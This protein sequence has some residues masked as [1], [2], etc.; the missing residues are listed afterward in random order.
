MHRTIR[1]LWTEGFI[2]GTKY[3]EEPIENGLPSRVIRYQLVSEV[4]QNFIALECQA[5][6]K[7]V[8]KAKYGISLF[9]KPFAYGLCVDEVKQV[10]AKVK[11]MLHKTHP[12]KQQGFS[13]QFNQ[14]TQCLAWIR[15]GI[16]LP[17]D[18]I[19]TVMGLNAKKQLL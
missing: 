7:K 11:A 12:D 16:P 3:I 17:T 5:I 6:Y 15:A 2:V 9:G 8:N 13:Q 1:D 4:T 14:M 10:T 18:D 19:S